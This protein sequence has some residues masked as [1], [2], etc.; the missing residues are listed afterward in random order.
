MEA[1]AAEFVLLPSAQS[2][3]GLQPRHCGEKT[4]ASRKHVIIPCAA[5][6]PGAGEGAVAA[7]VM[8]AARAVLEWVT[9]PVLAIALGLPHGAL[10]YW[11]SSSTFSLGQVRQLAALHSRHLFSQSDA[12]QGPPGASAQYTSLK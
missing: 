8:G 3:L 7:Y 10:V 9:V 12:F 1:A 5:W 2:P 6:F 11:L 4:W